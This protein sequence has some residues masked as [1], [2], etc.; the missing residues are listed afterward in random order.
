MNVVNGSTRISC[1][2]S[3]GFIWVLYNYFSLFIYFLLNFLFCFVDERFVVSQ[4]GYN[5]F[6]QVIFDHRKIRYYW[7]YLLWGYLFRHHTELMLVL[8]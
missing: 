2:D 5:I 3:D 8:V 4:I 1:G 6:R 7:V